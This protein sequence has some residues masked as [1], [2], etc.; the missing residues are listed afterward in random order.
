[1]GVR[2]CRTGVC[3]CAAM[4][5]SCLSV[6]W[7]VAGRFALCVEERGESTKKAAD[8]AVKAICTASF[9]DG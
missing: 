9:H 2:T 4:C 6:T 5:V 3:V 8:G 7:R 1:M